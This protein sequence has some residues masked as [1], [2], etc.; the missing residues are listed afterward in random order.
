MAIDLFDAQYYAAQNPDLAAAGIDTEAELRDHFQRYGLLEGRKFSPWVDLDYYRNSYSDLENFNYADLLT[1]LENNGV[2]EGRRFSQAFDLKYY[3]ANNADLNQAFGGDEERAFQHLIAQGINENRVFL[4]GEN[5]DFLKEYLAAN[6]DVN[7]SVGGSLEGAL[8]HLITYGF[9]EG[10]SGS[11]ES[12]G[13]ENIDLQVVRQMYESLGRGDYTSF[14]DLLTEDTVWTF[15]GDSSIIPFAGQWE[16]RDGVLEF[17]S[18][19]DE[20]VTSNVF[21]IRGFFQGESQIVSLLHEDLTVKE[22]GSEY[23][24][25]V[26]NLI[27]VTDGQISRLEGVFDSAISEAAFLGENTAV[28]QSRDALTGMSLARSLSGAGTQAVAQQQNTAQVSD[29]FDDSGLFGVSGAATAPLYTG[30]SNSALGVSDSFELQTAEQNVFQ[31]Q[32]LWAISLSP[33]S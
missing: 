13:A 18:T 16:G 7:K 19:R 14:Q 30:V 24:I 8:E 4:R 26:Y 5:R 3:L 25:E 10:R 21:E 15:S 29:S 32:Q 33:V 17:F 6:P 11:Q 23:A 9:A 1:H 2:R 27:T 31:P 28:A 12:F 20:F 22:N